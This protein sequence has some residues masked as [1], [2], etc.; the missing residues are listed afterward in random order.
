[1][2]TVNFKNVQAGTI[3]E[4]L[5]EWT[6]KTI[7]PTKDLMKQ[8]LAI[9]APQKL[10]RSE[11]IAL[12]LN[13]L[14]SKG[15]TAEETDDTIYL[16]P[17]PEEQPGKKAKESPDD[18]PVTRVYDIYDLVLVRA[19]ISRG[20]V[21]VTMD[22]SDAIGA[23]P[24]NIP[25][26][27]IVNEA[28]KIVNLNMQT[29][30]PN[31]WFQNNPNAKGIVTP[32]PPA[33]PRKLA[34]YQ[35]LPVHLK[36]EKF[37]KSQREQINKTQISIEMRYLYTN[38]EFLD[39]VRD[40]MDIEFTS[41]TIL[42]DKQL[43]TLLRASQK[44]RNI[45]YLMA[46]AATVF[47][48]ETAR[49]SIARHIFMSFLDYSESNNLSRQSP[50]VQIRITPHIEDN[51]NISIDFLQDIPGLQERI[52]YD[53][54][55]MMQ[56]YA[57]TTA[58]TNK[59]IPSNKTFAFICD[60]RKVIQGNQALS[61]DEQKTLIVLIKP[62]IIIQEEMPRKEA[63]RMLITPRM[64]GDTADQSDETIYLNP[65]PE[66]QHITDKGQILI[67]VKI[68]T[69]SDEFLRYIGLDPNSVVN[70]ESWSD[71]LVHST[72]DSASFVID[73]LHTDLLLRNVAA[74]MRT[75]KDIQMLQKPQVLALSG[76]KLEI[77]IPQSKSGYYILRSLSEPNALSGESESESNRIELGTTVRLTP[78]L[79][80]DGKNVELDFEW[81]Y[82]RL[83]G[84]KEHT[85][86]D[87]NVQKV[88]QI[89]VDSIKTPCMIPDGKTLLIAGKKIT[90]QKKKEPRKLGLTDLP[91]IGRFLYRPRQ[92]EE[93]KNLLLMVKAR[94]NPW[95][96]APPGAPKKVPSPPPTID[97]NDPLIKKLEEKFNHDDEKNLETT[98]SSQSLIFCNFFI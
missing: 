82:R 41:D 21:D 78:T 71:Y 22:R 16:K 37:L 77:H 43:E 94:I 29:I 26:Q 74:R 52:I 58:I 24:V 33:R 34:I 69:V 4:K 13:S 61:P 23:S 79:T 7:I 28:Q 68:L 88:P 59:R 42:D 80:P 5:A 45:K 97:P 51:K 70:S 3:I 91:L 76:K 90:V 98:A 86:P 25:D 18:K 38:A 6:G 11:A 12:I 92:V 1:M 84:F 81:E 36:I 39:E 50:P 89:D 72:E 56:S 83:R 66:E 8:K 2:E 15:Y 27:A 75:H 55:E 47:N 93:T 32:F 53:R 85:G 62:S 14:R 19:R 65:L 57:E 96:K 40:S 67:D 48:N 64:K 63:S 20:A 44:K 10:S 30:D 54:R 46:P 49:L 31:S 87:G 73:Q 35:T 17:L 60:I 95:K 9:H